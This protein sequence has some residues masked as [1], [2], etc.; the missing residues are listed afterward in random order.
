MRQK[1]DQGLNFRK[2]TKTKYRV[3]N[4]RSSGTVRLYNAYILHT[5]QQL[6][7]SSRLEN[8]IGIQNRSIHLL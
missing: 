6:C 5:L 7:D 1:I 3:Q 4:T 2:F 8:I